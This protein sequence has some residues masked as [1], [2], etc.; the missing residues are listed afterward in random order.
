MWKSF[1]NTM[2]GLLF[3]S[4]LKKR[5]IWQDRMRLFTVIRPISD[6]WDEQ[7]EISLCNALLDSGAKFLLS[8]WDHNKYRRNEYIDHLWGFCN[9]QTKEHFYHVGAKEANRNS[10]VE[11]LLSNYSIE[12]KINPAICDKEQMT[13]TA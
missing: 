4:L 1:S 6:G 12:V 13:F 5:Y 3:A 11:A 9:K 2:I 8:T 10:M 7:S